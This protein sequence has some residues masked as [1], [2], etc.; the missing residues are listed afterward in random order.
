MSYSGHWQRTKKAKQTIRQFIRGFFSCRPVVQKVIGASDSSFFVLLLLLV[1]QGLF[2]LVLCIIENSPEICHGIVR[3]ESV[4]V[5]IVREYREVPALYSLLAAV[6]VHFHRDSQPRKDA[7]ATGYLGKLCSTVF[8]MVKS[9]PYLEAAFCE[10]REFFLFFKAAVLLEDTLGLQLEDML[11][12]LVKSQTPDGF[13]GSVIEEGS[14]SHSHRLSPE[15]E[16]S[17]DLLYAAPH[18]MVAEAFFF[19][20]FVTRGDTVSLVPSRQPNEDLLCLNELFS[21]STSTALKYVSLLGLAEAEGNDG[22]VTGK[23]EQL[24]LQ[25]QSQLPNARNREEELTKRMQNLRFD[26]FSEEERR[27]FASQIYRAF[28]LTGKVVQGSKS[29]AYPFA[30]EL[31]KS[32]NYNDMCVRAAIRSV[33]I[34]G[35]FRMLPHSV[36]SGA[37]PHLVSALLYVLYESAP[38]SAVV[39]SYIRKMKQYAGKDSSVFT[40][41][42]ATTTV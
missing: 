20:H 42:L 28:F 16:V 19:Y 11:Q 25:H 15:K 13:A 7:K 39:I 21:S 37:S 23:K 17:V 5:E 8:G 12:L 14:G 32:Y 35:S 38:N 34:H 33:E 27:V 31:G 2:G 26:S 29:L 6:F 18:K 1:K 3:H 4:P 40:R 41:V 22:S 30:P 36:L 10:M 24:N 9:N